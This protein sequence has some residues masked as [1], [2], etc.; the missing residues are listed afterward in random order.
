MT[1]IPQKCIDRHSE[2]RFSVKEQLSEVVFINPSSRAVNQIV[3]DGCV[4]KE[5]DGKRCDHLI[6]V[7]ETNTSIFV[8]LKGS[9]IE[10]AFEQLSESHDKLAQYTNKR[11]FWIVSY[12]GSPRITSSIQALINKAARTKRARL[13][14]E[15]STYSHLL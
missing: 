10:A 3:V 2:L 8:E 1:S 14:V 15:E 9:N 4:F 12:S 6:N 13:L 7:D 5:G 11:V